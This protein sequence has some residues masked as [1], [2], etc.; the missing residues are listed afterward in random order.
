M[1]KGP[2]KTNII[3]Q[4]KELTVKAKIKDFIDPKDLPKVYSSADITVIPSL[5]EPFGFVTLESL[6]CGTPVIGSDLGGMRDIIN[7]KIGLKIKLPMMFKRIEKK[8]PGIALIDAE[9]TMEF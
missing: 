6:A 9:A 3:T 4:I 1:G 8:I 7:E 5:T 2:E